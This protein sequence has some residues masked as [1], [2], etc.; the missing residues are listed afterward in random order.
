MASPPCSSFAIESCVVR[1]LPETRD[2]LRDHI[3]DNKGHYLSKYLKMFSNE[4][5]FVCANIFGIEA[6]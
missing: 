1:S 4:S 5:A 3:V 6:I 2:S